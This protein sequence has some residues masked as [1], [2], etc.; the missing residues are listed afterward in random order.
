VAAA[1]AR[2]DLEGKG[3]GIGMADYRIAGICLSRSAILLTRNRR[4]YE[5]VPG[6]TGGRLEV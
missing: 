1:A 4:H 3:E 6:L 5:R 2:Q